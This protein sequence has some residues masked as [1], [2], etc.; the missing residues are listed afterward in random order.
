MK[1]KIP[2]KIIGTI[3]GI[4]SLSSSANVEYYIFNTSEKK[5]ISFNLSLF[6]LKIFLANIDFPLIFVSQPT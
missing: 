4:L 1:K 3:S 6:I 2:Y 5:F